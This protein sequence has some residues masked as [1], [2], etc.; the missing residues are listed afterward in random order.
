MGW[1]FNPLG[2]RVPVVLGGFSGLAE[3]QDGAVLAL[4]GE[5][6]VCLSLGRRKRA[7][8]NYTK[9]KFVKL[10]CLETFDQWASLSKPRH[11][12]YSQGRVHIT[13]RGLH[14]VLTVELATGLQAAAGYLGSGPG[15]WRRP[16]GILADE[17]GNLL[18]VDRD[19]HRLSIFSRT[20]AFVRTVV[21]EW[22]SPGAAGPG[23]R[24]GAALRR[25]GDAVWL[26]CTGAGGGG[27]ALVRFQVKVGAEE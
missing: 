24:G 9:W 14:K 17:A 1:I 25:V 20:G 19:N 10:D 21:S 3:G 27:G 15:Q 6:L 7:R 23:A 26:V 11:L 18:V 22:A 12:A 8:R 5:F 4:R 2:V 16:A 13:D